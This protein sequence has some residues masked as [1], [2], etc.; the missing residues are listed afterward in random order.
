MKLHEAAN[1]DDTFNAQ[2]QVILRAVDKLH[3]LKEKF[4]DEKPVVSSQTDSLIHCKG[5]LSSLVQDYLK[6]RK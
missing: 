3:A 6:L 5:E 1:A 2:I 4:G